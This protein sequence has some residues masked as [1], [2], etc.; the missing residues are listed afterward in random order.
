MSNARQTLATFGVL[1]ELP[2]AIL[3]GLYLASRWPKP[4]CHDCELVGE[5]TLFATLSEPNDRRP[6]SPDRPFGVE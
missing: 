1:I 6:W 4:E 5:D 2:V 3:V